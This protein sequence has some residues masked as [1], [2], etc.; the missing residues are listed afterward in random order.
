MIIG[1]GSGS[2]W[3]RESGWASVSI[4]RTTLERRV[5]FGS[6][7]CGTVNFAEMMAYLQPLNWYAAVELTKRKKSKS[8]QF[9]NVHIITDS[10][11]CAEQGVKKDT[12]PNKNSGLWRIFSDFQRHGILIHWHWIPRDTVELNIYA[13]K[14]SKEARKSIAE[15]KKRMKENDTDTSSPAIEYTF[16]P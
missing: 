5:W 13:D 6:M 11:Y 14:L 7:N 4:D 1:D 16:N 12:S 9:K 2:N 8:V 15:L 3:T 10:K